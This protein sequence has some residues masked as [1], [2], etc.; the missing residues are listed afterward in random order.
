MND[1]TYYA[2]NALTGL[3]WN[4]KSFSGT[5]DQA[6]RISYEQIVLIRYCWANVDITE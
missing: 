3:Y 4:G 2:K 1:K 6:Q 5:K